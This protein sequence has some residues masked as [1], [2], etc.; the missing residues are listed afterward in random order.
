MATAFLVEFASAVEAL[1]CAVDIQKALT[2]LTLV[3][4]SESGASR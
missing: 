4:A 1:Q 3:V 2:A